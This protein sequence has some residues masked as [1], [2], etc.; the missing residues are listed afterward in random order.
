VI[1]EQP[2]SVYVADFIGDVNLIEGSVF[3]LE[4]GAELAWAEGRAPL[5]GQPGAALTKGQSATFAIRPE[6]IAISADEPQDR[7]NRVQGK[8][9]DIGY[10]GNLSTYHVQMPEGPVIKC[11]VGNRSRIERRDFTWEDEVW[12]SWSDTA[13]LVLAR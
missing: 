2:N 7:R 10:L 5:V 11:E 1:Y 3:S 13:G 4:G 8:I 12:L 9:L 6:K